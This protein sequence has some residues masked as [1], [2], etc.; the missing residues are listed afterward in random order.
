VLADDA[1]FAAPG[2][3]ALLRRRRPPAV[4]GGR[5]WRKLGDPPLVETVTRVGYRR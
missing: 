3:R 1:T 4:E 5:L 2:L